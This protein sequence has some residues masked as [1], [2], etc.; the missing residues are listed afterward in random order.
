M[1]IV[2]DNVNKS[3]DTDKIIDL[4]NKAK[5]SNNGN[6]SFEAEED[7]ETKIEQLNQ[8]ST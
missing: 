7:L 1:L 5:Q 8:K 2:E 6:S 3:Q 4:D